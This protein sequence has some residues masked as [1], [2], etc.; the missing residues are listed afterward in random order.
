MRRYL[1]LPLSLLTAL[2]CGDASPT[3]GTDLANSSEL[4]AAAD[5]GGVV[6]DLAG[7]GDA[8]M[9]STQ[10]P[11]IGTARELEQW[12]GTGA[13]KS[14]ACEKDLHPARA[15]S[16]HAANRICSNDLLSGSAS[17]EFPVNSASVKELY[18]SGGNIIGYAVG[19]RTMTGATDNAWFWYERVNTSVYAN[20][21]GVPLCANCHRGAPRDYTF[22]QVK[23]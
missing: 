3:R 4:G 12:L 10:L 15:G 8:T 7:A 16:A 1:V 2:A 6:A 20:G 18:D 5:F 9:G 11:P 14:W 21:V 19:V 17:G 13:Y 22:T 23:R